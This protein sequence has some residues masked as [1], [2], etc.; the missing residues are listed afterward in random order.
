MSRLEAL[1]TLERVYSAAA[2]LSGDNR[3][4]HAKHEHYRALFAQTC[5][6]ASILLDTDGDGR[7]ET[8]RFLSVIDLLRV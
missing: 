2:A 8:R 3:F 1:G 4:V 5:R 7:G 6:R